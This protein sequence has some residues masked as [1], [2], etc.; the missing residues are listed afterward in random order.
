MTL[1]KTLGEG[2]FGKVVM[3]EAVGILSK[4][5]ATQVAVKMLKREFCLG[6]YEWISL[7][8]NSSSVCLVC[9]IR[10]DNICS[11]APNIRGFVVN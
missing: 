8:D 11:M 2:A 5:T 3:G 4:E 7:F 10:F 1:G 9:G 6:Y